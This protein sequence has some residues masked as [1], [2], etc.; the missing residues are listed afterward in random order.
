ML[1]DGG[2]PP[3]LIAQDAAIAGGIVQLHG[4]KRQVLIIHLLQQALQGLGL[5]QGHVAIEDQYPLRRQRRR[6]LG[7][8]MAGAELLG[9]DHEADVVGGQLAADL[10][11]AMA[12][13][14][15]DA[16]RLQFAGAVEDMP[17]HAAT[18]HGMQH[19]G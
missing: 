12:D 3:L 8:G 6:R 11:G 13:D 10:V 7:D 2:Y 1:D 14:D 16:G 19:L 5:D 9:L 18:G 15:V 4:Q 17:Q